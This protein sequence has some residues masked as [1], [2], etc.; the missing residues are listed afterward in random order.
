MSI[1]CYGV[2]AKDFDGKPWE[3][4]LPSADQFKVFHR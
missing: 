2:K 3:E 4:N 1:A